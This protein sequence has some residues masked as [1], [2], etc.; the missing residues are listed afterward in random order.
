MHVCILGAGG[1]GS[2]IGGKLAESGVDVT[3]VARPAHA[4]AIRSDGLRIVGASG[5]RVVRDRLVAVDHARH[6]DGDIDHALLLVKTK[7][8]ATI[9][10]ESSGLVGRF[11]TISSLQNSVTK[12]ATL[13]AWAGDRAIGAS[14]TEAATLL[15]PGVVRHTGTAPV[16]FYFGELDGTASDRVGELVA[17]FSGAGLAAA[18]SQ[19]I[20]HVEWEKLMQISL[21]AAFSVSLLGFVPGANVA[22]GMRLRPGAE[23]YVALARELLAVYEA[24]GYEPCDFFA[25]YARFRALRASDDETAVRDVMALGEQMH[26][27]GVRGLPSLHDDLLRGRTTEV[28]DCVGRFVAEAERVGVTTPTLRAAWRTIRALELFPFTGDRVPVA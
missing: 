21:V 28:D 18:E 7:D 11:R 16:A 19:D 14:T 8:T 22:D 4:A 17:A 2:L 15:A 23:H 24:M 9:L 13:R 6:V 3:L 1:L 20:A 10:G 25:P 26:A 27:A 12:D 5:E